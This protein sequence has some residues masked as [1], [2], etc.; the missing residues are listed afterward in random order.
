MLALAIVMAFVVGVFWAG[1]VGAEP[2]F[3]PGDP[4]AGLQQA[5]DA[6]GCE[7]GEPDCTVAP[8]EKTGQTTSYATGDDGDLKKGVAWPNPR[9]TDNLNGTVTDNL[10]GLIWLKQANYNSTTGST[11]TATWGEAL[12]FANDLSDGECGLSDFS[13]DGDW[14]LPNVKELQSLIDYGNYNP[15]LPTGHLFSGVQSY[16][17]WSSTTHAD[18]PGAAWYVGLGHGGVNTTHKGHHHYVWPVRGGE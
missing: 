11:G 6:L 5:A 14:R 10:T 16:Y 3:E 18:G 9:F 7:F 17:Y 8:V 2:P 15:C 13:V 12:S 4:C 1:P